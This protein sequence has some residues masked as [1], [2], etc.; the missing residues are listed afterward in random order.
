MNKLSVASDGKSPIYAIN[1]SGTGDIYTCSLLA[2]SLTTLSVPANA[3]VAVFGL[4]VGVDYWVSD[5]SFAIPTGNSFAT[6]QR[7][8][9][10][11]P[12][13]VVTGI[14]TLYFIAPIACTISVS[15]YG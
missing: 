2:G 13:L 6:T 15:F 11:P 4:A 9:L 3:R 8:L 7:A 1:L 10:N 12:P 14:S 5:S